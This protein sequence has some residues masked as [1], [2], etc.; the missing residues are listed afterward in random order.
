MPVQT[1]DKINIAANKR[2]APSALWFLVGS[3]S[4]DQEDS[5]FCVCHITSD[6]KIV[7]TEGEVNDVVL[8]ASRIEGQK[9]SACIDQI[10]KLIL[11]ID[12]PASEF[13]Y[14]IP[15]DLDGVNDLP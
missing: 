3:A 15:D 14:V 8:D 9:I 4:W 1:A 5:C 12:V 2:L 10:L 6:E 11:V 7:I 13:K